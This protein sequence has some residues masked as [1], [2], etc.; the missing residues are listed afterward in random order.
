MT[1]WSTK[2]IDGRCRGSI[3]G[4]IA[5]QLFEEEDI[6]KAARCGDL[7]ELERLIDETKDVDVL[8]KAGR[9]ALHFAAGFGR[10]A[11][12]RLLLK[13]GAR[14]EVRDVWSKAP[15]D[16]ALQ[17]KQFETVKLMRI[18]AIERNL[19]IGARGIERYVVLFST[20]IN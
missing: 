9:T 12:T 15:V 8:D 10:V 19:D 7:R 16:F 13:R 18:E 20:H 2:T 14:L 4:A 5:H 6:H 1:K 3:D 11:C 17:A